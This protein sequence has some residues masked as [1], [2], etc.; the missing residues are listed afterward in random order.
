[1]SLFTRKDDFTHCSQDEDHCFRRVDL[2]IGAHGKSYKGRQW[3]MIPYNYNL[4]STSFDSMSIG[5]QFNDLLNEVN[6]YPPFTMVYG[7]Y[8]QNYSTGS[9]SID[10]NY[11][12]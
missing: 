12:M 10:D 5:T 8:P 4:F 11:G 1:M 9:S 3:K 7:Q 2:G 6:I